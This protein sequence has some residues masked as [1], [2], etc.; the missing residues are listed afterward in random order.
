MDVPA[1]DPEET[2][3]VSENVT[4]TLLDDLSKYPPFY[5]STVKHGTTSC[6]PR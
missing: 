2:P 4:L 5:P 1:L 3:P 6:W